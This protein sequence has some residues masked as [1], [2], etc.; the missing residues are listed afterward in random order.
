M[1]PKILSQAGNSLADVYDIEGSIA[2]IDQLETKELPIVHEM[3]ATVFSE[4]LSG[5][6]VRATTGDIAQNITFNVTMTGLGLT[7]QRILAIGVFADVNAR[8]DRVVVS[9]RDPVA[10]REVPIFV[11]ST[12]ADV[13]TAM[14]LQDDDGAV[15]S[16][17]ALISALPVIVP[18]MLLGSDQPQAVNEIV[19][20]GI[21]QGFGAGTVE[22]VMVVYT[23]F[24]QV[25]GVSSR[26][27]PLPSW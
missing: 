5:R 21:T 8:A 23:A 16:V 24:A 27:L 9:I 17:F 12:A 20:R 14:R 7:A 26:G 15:A 11:W 22:I 1:T 3:G 18:N 6:I 4:R 19:M 2:G 10:G 13:E 25:E